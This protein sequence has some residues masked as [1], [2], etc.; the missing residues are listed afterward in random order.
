MKHKEKTGESLIEKYLAPIPFQN[1]S[2]EKAVKE[3]EA[4][5]QKLFSEFLKIYAINTLPKEL[6]L[7]TFEAIKNLHLELVLEQF[8]GES[9]DTLFNNEYL[10]DFTI[11]LKDEEGKSESLR[12]NSS[13]LSARSGYYKSFFIN[14]FGQE[15]AESELQVG[16][17]EEAKE[18]IAFMHS[19]DY[20]RVAR[21]IHQWRPGV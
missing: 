16:N 11:T 14:V 20:A 17:I 9:F 5:R 18:A 21:I 7:L 3:I 1:A 2:Q 15:K 6:L 8:P 4:M 13:F 12:V 19:K 10:S